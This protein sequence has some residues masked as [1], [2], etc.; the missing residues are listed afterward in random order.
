MVGSKLPR[1]TEASVAEA[2]AADTTGLA[3][4]TLG[5]M[6]AVG[7]GAGVGM[8]VAVGA[9]AK[10][11][12]GAGVGAGAAVAMPGAGTMGLGAGTPFALAT[13]LIVGAMRCAEA[14]RICSSISLRMRLS[15]W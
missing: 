6:A 9:E 12:A 10:A 15:R 1:G 11:G 14:R 4:S 7:E 2:G 5:A 13:S 3:D 8:A